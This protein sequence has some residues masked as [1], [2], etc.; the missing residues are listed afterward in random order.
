MRCEHTYIRINMW[1]GM[2]KLFSSMF[3]A[4]FAFI[5]FTE[6]WQENMGK[7]GFLLD[8]MVRFSNP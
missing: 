2:R 4:I 7:E 8:Y 1:Y 5:I 3:W 6:R